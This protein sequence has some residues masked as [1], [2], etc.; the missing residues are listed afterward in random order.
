MTHGSLLGRDPS[1]TRS[2]LAWTVRGAWSARCRC[3]P[4]TVSKLSSDIVASPGTMLAPALSTDREQQKQHILTPVSAKAT[5]AQRHAHHCSICGAARHTQ[6]CLH[7]RTL[8]HAHTRIHACA[9]AHTYKY[10]RARVYTQARTHKYTCM[11]TKTDTRARAQTHTY[12]QT[13]RHT[14]AQ[15]HIHTRTHTRAHT[16]AH[17]HTHAQTHRHTRAHTHIHTYTHM[18]MHAHVLCVM[19]FANFSAS[20]ATHPQTPRHTRARTHENT[21][22]HSH[23]H[24]HMHACNIHFR[25]KKGENYYHFK[26]EGKLVDATSVLVWTPLGNHPPPNS[27]SSAPTRRKRVPLCYFWNSASICI[28]IKTWNYNAAELW[29]KN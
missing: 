5:P 17:T 23:A 16:H 26:R 4:L 12:T 18:Y 28:I 27:P 22:T 10:K 2:V 6:A 7:T 25:N 8:V 19:G 24:M 14:R 15:K 29:G 9:R 20:L 13:H 3:L 1:G 21:H 11:R